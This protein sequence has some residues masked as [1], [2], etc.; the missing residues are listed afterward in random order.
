MFGV[1]YRCQ[2][3]C[4]YCCS[5]KYL[6]V[7][8]E[9]L[10]TDELKAI[11]NQVSRLPSLFTVVSFFGGECMLRDDIY[12]LIKY[13]AAQGLFTEIESNGILL[14]RGNIRRLKKAGLHHAF[15]RIESINPSTHDT[16][17]NY[18]GCFDRAVEAITNCVDE[19]LSCTISTVAIRNKIYNNELKETIELGRTLGVTSV[20]ILYPTLA[21]NWL[22]KESEILTD[23]EKRGVK[24]LLRPDFVYLESTYACT[25]ESHRI[26]PSVQK[27]FFYISPYGEVQPCP[28]VP[29]KFGSLRRARLNDILFN[30]WRQPFFGRKK[31]DGC[32]MNNKEFRDKLH[33]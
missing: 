18:A 11:I 23:E 12:R 16:I 32:L 1:T 19:E 25:K 7:P 27:K 5:G 30:M 14:S 21:G 17:S 29:L 6:N 8:E 26:C 20:R 13:S 4:D 15:V 3:A 31:D 10:S 2:C 22:D 9:E 28:F 24:E 33:R